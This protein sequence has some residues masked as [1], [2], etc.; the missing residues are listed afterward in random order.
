VPT[1]GER[2]RPGRSPG[3]QPWQQATPRGRETRARATSHPPDAHEYVALPLARPPCTPSLA[4]AEAASRASRSGCHPPQGI[5]QPRPPTSHVVVTSI[6]SLMTLPLV[7][8]GVMRRA[9]VAC[10]ELLEP[11]SDVFRHGFGRSRV[12]SRR[13]LWDA[14]GAGRVRELFARK[15]HPQGR[16][17][18]THP[19]DRTHRCC[20]RRGARSRAFGATR[21]CGFGRKPAW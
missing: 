10:S 8:R 4:R 7:P 12:Y 3:G 16:S 21:A 2:R 1:N 19:P 20:S 11:A 15:G 5:G 17:A 13:R 18:A 9:A 14:V 6:R